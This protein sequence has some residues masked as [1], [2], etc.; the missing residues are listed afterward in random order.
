MKQMDA[1][2]HSGRTPTRAQ[3]TLVP[4]LIKNQ[5]NEKGYNEPLTAWFTMEG[6]GGPKCKICIPL[7]QT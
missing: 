2:H 1:W 4:R 6:T 3:T 7:G 5:S